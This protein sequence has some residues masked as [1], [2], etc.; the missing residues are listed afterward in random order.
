M[1]S[2][3]S[4]P[5]FTLSEMMVVLV[6]TVIVVALAFAVL[7]LVRKQTGNIIVNQDRTIERD[8][9]MSRLWIDFHSYP[10]ICSA[11]GPEA[12]TL[13]FTNE[14]QAAR[15]TFYRDRTLRD[16]D[17]FPPLDTLTFLSG[18]AKVTDGKIDALLVQ[19]QGF[20]YR[21]NDAAHHLND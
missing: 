20:I 19:G 15:Y 8:R 10:T 3:N 16:L 12:R 13:E 5:S 2:K 21:V 11:T 6:I 17:T 18:G 9:L 1:K 14:G 7:D 4:M